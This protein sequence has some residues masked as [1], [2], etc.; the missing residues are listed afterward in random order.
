MLSDSLVHFAQENVKE[1]TYLT[2]EFWKFGHDCKWDVLNE[3]QHTHLILN[4]LGDKE[5]SVQYNYDGSYTFYGRQEALLVIPKL[6]ST[7]LLLCF[8]N[9]SHIFS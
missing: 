2:E 3:P 9:V 4:A 8:Y 7:R 6:L 5:T 1:M